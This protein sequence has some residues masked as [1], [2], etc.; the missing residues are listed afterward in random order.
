[1]LAHLHFPGRLASSRTASIN[2]IPLALAKGEGWG[3]GAFFTYMEDD[4]YPIKVKVKNGLVI[5]LDSRLRG[6]DR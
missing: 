3:E 5:I 6:N 4:T 1:L 2:G